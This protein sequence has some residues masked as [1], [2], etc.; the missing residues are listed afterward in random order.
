MGLNIFYFEILFLYVHI[1]V[2]LYLF[3]DHVESWTGLPP[4][5]QIFE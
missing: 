2:V 3:N 5:E 4:P 1:K